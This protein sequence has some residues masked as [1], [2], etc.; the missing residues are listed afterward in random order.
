MYNYC[1]LSPFMMT[2]YG[3]L[4]QLSALSKAGGRGKT[5]LTVGPI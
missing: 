2:K 4:D 1:N 5:R 3:T